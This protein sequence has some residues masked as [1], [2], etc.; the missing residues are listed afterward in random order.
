[1]RLRHYILDDDAKTLLI[2][3]ICIY[4]MTDGW[5]VPS[6]TKMSRTTPVEKLAAA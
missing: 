6:S 2:I 3:N 5:H 4:A 1:M